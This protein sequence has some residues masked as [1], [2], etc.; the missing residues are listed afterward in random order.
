MPPWLEGAL[1]GEGDFSVVVLFTRLTIAAILGSAIGA[2]HFASQR[3]PRAQVAPFTTTLALLAVLIAMVTLV[4]GNNIARAFGLVGALS[5]VRF[6]TVVDDTRDTAFVIFAVVVGMAT[7]AGYW[8]LTLIGAPIVALVS[9][10]WAAWGQNG[11]KENG[12]WR[13]AIRVGVGLDPERLLASNFERATTSRR[14]LSVSTARQG[15]AIEMTYL[16]SLQASASPQEF[17]AELN[18][19]EGVQQV[20]LKRD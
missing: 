11:A 19:V 15:A 14:A 5:I 18:R 2:I 8:A 4:I 20:E 10:A 1:N 17:V 12:D 13:L 7:G 6:R 16:V 9:F 3:K